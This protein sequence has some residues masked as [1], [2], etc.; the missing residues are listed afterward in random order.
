MTARS[1]VLSN[2]TIR[3]EK[4]LRVPWRFEPLHGIVNLSAILPSL[5]LVWHNHSCDAGEVINCVGSHR[6]RKA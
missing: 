2:R 6:G 5:G 4:A 1:E 3:G